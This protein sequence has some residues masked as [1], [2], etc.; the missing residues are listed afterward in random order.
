MSTLE[1]TERMMVPAHAQTEEEYTIDLGALFFALLDKWHM[2]LLFSL[3]GMLLANAYAFF[4][5]EPS[6]IS[7]AKLYVVSA[8]GDSAV[9]LTDLNIGTSLTN[10]YRELIMSYPVL[11]QVIDALGLDMTSEGLAKLIT[12]SN[13]QNTRVLTIAAKTKDAKLSERIANTLAGVA[14]EYLP[15]TMSTPRPNVAQVAKVAT[16][17][18]DPS[19]VKMTLLGGILAF[20]MIAGYYAIRF[21]TDDTIQSPEDIEKTF[22]IPVIT[23]IP[24]NEAMHLSYGDKRRRQ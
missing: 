21:L 2:I 1:K 24:E 16:K 9:D 13:P 5:I 19:Y 4:C 23:S 22:G 12:I 8:S 11:D 15:E 18:S 7:T 6:Y 14:Q 20:I 10:D 17:K 3:V